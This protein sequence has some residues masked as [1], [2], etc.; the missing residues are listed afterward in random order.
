MSKRLR[1]S[2]AERLAG[3]RLADAGYTILATNYRSRAGEIDIVALLDELI[4]FVEVKQRTG[5]RYGRAEEAVDG[6]KIQRILS[7]ADVFIAEHPEHADR[8][9]RLDLIAIT[10]DRAGEVERFDHIENL[11][12]D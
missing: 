9:W 11:V 4:V 5:G 1:G 7:T 6:A 3:E 2:E 12:V 10:L 8:I